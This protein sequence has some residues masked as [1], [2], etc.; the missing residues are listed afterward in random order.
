MGT[1]EVT[2]IFC[3]AHLCAVDA[4]FEIEKLERFDDIVPRASNK[5]FRYAF[6]VLNA[7]EHNDRYKFV[8]L[9]LADMRDQ[10]YAGHF[11]HLDV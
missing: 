11:R 5:S 1:S 9:N 3:I 8:A 2:N 4:R 6:V 7:G 10:L